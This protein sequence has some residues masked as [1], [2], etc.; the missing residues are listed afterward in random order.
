MTNLCEPPVSRKVPADLA[1]VISQ[2]LSD[3]VVDLDRARQRMSERHSDDL[4]IWFDKL[5]DLPS[6]CLAI[7]LAVLNGLSYESVVR[8]A[9]R[10]VAGLDGP[11]AGFAGDEPV[12]L[13][14][15]REPFRF[16]RRELV[17]RLRAEIR[18]VTVRGAWG[19]VTVEAIQYVADGYPALVLNHVWRELQIHRELLDW[20]GT[21]R[22]RTC[23]PGEQALGVLSRHAFDFV[24]AQV[25]HQL[26]IAPH[27]S[28]NGEVVAYALRVPAAD[29]RTR[30]WSKRWSTTSTPTAPRRRGRRPRPA[31]T[32]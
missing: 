28:R 2:E 15:W 4:D 7:A 32:A 31:C 18:S 3:G 24:Y 6:R 1:V 25:L 26:A 14:P 8:A 30:P 17:R 5:P 29:D 16:S 19:P 10:L 13:R 20:L 11:A 12:A 27:N 21:G 23:A 9:D 22:R